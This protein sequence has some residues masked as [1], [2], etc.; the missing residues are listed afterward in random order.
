MSKAEELA[1]LMVKARSIFDR[2]DVLSLDKESQ[3]EACRELNTGVLSLSAIGAVVGVTQYRVEKAIAGMPRPTNRGHLN[4]AHLTWLAYGLSK[5]DVKGFWVRA[6]LDGG[7]SMSTIGDLTMISEATLY[8][9]RDE[10]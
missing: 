1:E 9:R 6:M 8:R 7:T 3:D 5:G 2:Q 4:P 10:R